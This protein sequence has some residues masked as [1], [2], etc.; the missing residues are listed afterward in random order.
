MTRLSLDAYRTLFTRPDFLR[1]LWLTAW[2]SL[3]STA[4]S[5]MLALASALLLR[6][7]LHTGGRKPGW[8]AFLYQLNLP[9]PHCVGAIAILLLFSQS[10]LLA[11]LAYAAAWI[12]A[13]SGFPALVFD[14]YGIGI[15]LEYLWKTTVFTGLILFAALESAGDE[16]EA[17]ASTLG[18]NPWQ[19]FRYVTLPLL[20]PALISASILVFAFTFGG[21]EVPYVLGQRSD[22]LLPVL[23]YRE[24][25]RVDLAARPQAMAISLVIAAVTTLLVWL[26]MR[27][28]ER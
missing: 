8:I 2:V 15:I 17:A 13:P 10:G 11:R 28:M 9:I 16:H 20:R 22:S 4:I 3:S 6:R 14:R 24:Y 27:W 7:A 1:S 12:E 18:A 25:T 5:T 21:Y 23:A 26:Y 19:R